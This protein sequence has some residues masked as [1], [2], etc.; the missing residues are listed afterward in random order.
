[1]SQAPGPQP[2]KKKSACGDISDW[3]VKMFYFGG[4][5]FICGRNIIHSQKVW[6]KIFVCGEKYINFMYAWNEDMDKVKWMVLKKCDHVSKCD[7]DLSLT[8]CNAHHLLPCIHTC[9]DDRYGRRSG[10]F[11]TYKTQ[12][13]RRQ[14][15]PH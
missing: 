15:K 7:W 1:M 3:I 11:Q 13:I 9:N 12:H 6:A 2:V 5:Q 10:W 4:K 8:F 14:S